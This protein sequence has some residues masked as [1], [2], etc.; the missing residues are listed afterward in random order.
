MYKVEFDSIT[1]YKVAIYFNN[2]LTVNTS[3][4]TD[5]NGKV[6]GTEVYVMDGNHNNGGWRVDH[7]Y[8]EVI[9]LIDAAIKGN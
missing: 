6:V 7:T 2:N 1:G 3:E 5:Y 8:E 4:K 9:S